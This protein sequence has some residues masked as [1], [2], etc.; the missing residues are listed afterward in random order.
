MHIVIA[1]IILAAVIMFHEL[2]HFL[3]ARACGITV[4]EF[5][6]GFGPKIISGKKGDTTYSWRLIPIGG[7]CQMLG[8]D[9]ENDSPGSFQNAKVWQRIIVVA[10]GPGFN[11]IL[12]LIAAMIVIF[13]AGADPASVLEVNP[14]SPAESAGLLPGDLIT[15]YEGSDIM[16]ARELYTFM[17]LDPVPKDSVD[18]TVERDG[19]RIRISYPPEVTGSYMLGYTFS[20]DELPA[21][22]GALTDGL[23]MKEAGVQIGDVITEINGVPVKSGAELAAYLQENPLDGSPVSLTYM[24]NTHE[25]TA[26]LTPVYYESASVGFAFNMAR[27]KQDFISSVAYSFGEVRYWLDVTVKSLVR[28]LTG[29]FALSDLS[30]PV[31]IVTAVGKVYQEAAPEGAFIV[32]MNM[33]SMLILIS[34]NVGV[35][36]LLPLPALDGGRLIFLII[37]AIRRKRVKQSIEGTIHFI[38][39]AALMALMVFIVFQDIARLM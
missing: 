15:S 27:E 18:L 8:E 14:G 11:F 24:H 34:A 3:A 36:N 16:N 37:E 17:R 9:E 25:L 23:P 32:L 19:K 21:E 28:L 20:P 30:G 5:A 29:R 39:F 35:M 1:I 33:M 12:A 2:G 38:G 4:V 10:A 13:S 31:G 26:E 22:I 7:M 6:F